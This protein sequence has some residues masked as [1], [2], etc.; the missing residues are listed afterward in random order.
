M[1]IAAV[2]RRSA[3]AIRSRLGLEAEQMDR[4]A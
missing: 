3:L 2:M 4:A 1:Q